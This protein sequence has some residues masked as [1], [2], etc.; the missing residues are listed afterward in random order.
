[1]RV[2]AALAQTEHINNLLDGENQNGN[3]EE[4]SGRKK[5]AG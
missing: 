2:H 1:M 5:S 4:G 3:C